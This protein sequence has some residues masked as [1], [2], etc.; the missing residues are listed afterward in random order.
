MSTPQVYRILAKYSRSLQPVS[1][2]EAFLDVTGL[3]DP[4]DMAQRI[5]AEIKAETRLDASAGIGPNPLLAKMAT[6]KAKPNGQTQIKPQVSLL[7]PARCQLFPSP[8]TFSVTM[9]SL[10]LL[11]P[12]P[13]HP[14][15]WPPSSATCP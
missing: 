12:S 1:C 11:L 13:S 9:A 5:R 2:D 15:M 4:L 10:I 8:L 6:T 3:G 14:R 7:L